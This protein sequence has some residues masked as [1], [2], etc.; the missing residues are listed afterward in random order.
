MN[1][2]VRSI[3]D[4]E[5]REGQHHFQVR[6]H[7]RALLPQSLC[8]ELYAEMPGRAAPFRRAM[9]CLTVSNPQGTDHL[10]KP[11]VPADPPARDYTPRGLPIIYPG[12]N[13]PLE[14]AHILWQR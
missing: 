6:V 5:T 12:V 13:V 9:T 3:L 4:V 8:V 1:C 11:S 14:A 2:G 10:Y 7:L